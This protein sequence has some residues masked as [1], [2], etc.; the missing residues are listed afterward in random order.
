VCERGKEKQKR[1]PTENRVT[2]DSTRAVY[3]G[4]EPSQAEDFGKV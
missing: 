4:G 2:K 3:K 1:L